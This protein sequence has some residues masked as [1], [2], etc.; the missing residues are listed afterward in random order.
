MTNPIKNNQTVS[1]KRTHRPII[2]THVAPA[3]THQ[4]KYQRWQEEPAKCIQER[5]LVRV[6]ARQLPSVPDS[7]VSFGHRCEL[8]PGCG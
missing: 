7:G 3:P 6:L 5:G 8:G 1:Q 4:K 2:Q